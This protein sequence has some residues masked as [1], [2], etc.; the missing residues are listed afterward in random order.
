MNLKNTIVSKFRR[1]ALGGANISKLTKKGMSVGDDLWLG[2]G[3][4]IDTTFC[5]L[6]SIGN[7]CTITSKVHILAHDASTKKHLGY[8]K[9]GR[10]DIGNDV[11]IG[12]GTIIL[13]GV[14]IGDNVIIAAGSVI[15]KSIPANEVWGGNPAKYICSKDEYIS[16]H[17]SK[18]V[19][20]QKEWSNE[21][22]RIKISEELKDY[23]IKY[24][25]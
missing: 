25:E 15:T 17:K 20:S 10:V 12:V 22:K 23:K 19:I 24:I 11:F 8:T 16:K 5:E 7:N 6:I 21:K 3:V 1:V 14:K 4:S 2:Y 13:P 9:I 18:N